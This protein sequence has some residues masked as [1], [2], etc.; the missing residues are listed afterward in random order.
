MP[1]FHRLKVREVRRETKDC[2]SVSFEIPEALGK[3]YAF[4]A[5]QYLTLKADIGG[6][7]VRRTYSICS[8]PSEADLRVAIKQVEGGKFS[9]F[10]NQRLHRGDELDVM[11]PLGNFF[12][13]LD[14]DHE[15]HYVAFAA[16]SGITP[17]I[18]ILKS[19]LEVEPKSVFTLF[20]GNKST[21]AIIFRESLEN[22]KNKYLDRLSIHHVF[23]REQAGTELFSG[24]ITAEKCAAFCDRLLDLEEVDEFFICGPYDMM[25]SVRDTL[26]SRGVDK[27]SIHVELFTAKNGQPVKKVKRTK[28]QEEDFEAS[29]TVKLDGTSMDFP[30]R[31]DGDSILDAALKGGADLPFACKGGV[32]STCKAR[33]LE[34]KVEMDVNYA[35]EEDEVEAGYILTCQSHPL[36]PKV[37]VDYDV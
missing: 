5:G 17:I 29:V 14:P 20:F 2:V 6:E 1:K 31:S 35:L 34:G 18:A 3:D 26:R 21:D 16:G 28:R 7:E 33:L 37:V 9:S 27:K 11:T 25:V 15:K 22:L 13:A 19:V 10:A 30:I 23:S 8:S 36:T 12:T 24:R 32:C 4:N